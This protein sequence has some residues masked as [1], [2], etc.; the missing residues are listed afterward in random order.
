MERASIDGT[1]SHT[2]SAKADGDG[3][4][5]LEPAQTSDSSGLL[6]ELE[7]RTGALDAAPTHFMIIDMRRPGWPIVFVNRAIARDNGY[8][9]E[10]LLGQGPGMLVTSP[11]NAAAL[12]EV[13]SAMRRGEPARAQLRSY[14]KDGTSFWAGVSFW[15]MR[16][17]AG[18]TTHYVSIGAD[19]TAR[20]EET[21]NRER[22]QRQLYDEMQQR[23]Q[24]AIE[25]RFA[26]KLESVG[27]L[28]AG[29]AHEINTPIQYIG[30]SVRF[31]QETFSSLDVLVDLCRRLIASLSAGSISAAEA[32]QRV[33]EAERQIDLEFLKTEAP[34]A[35]ERTLDGV[36]RVAS[37]V[38]AMKEFAHPDANEQALAD[39]NHAIETTLTVAHSEYKYFATVDMRFDHLPEV[40]CNI[41]EL[42]QVFLNLIVNAAHAIEQSGKDAHMGRIEISTKLQGAYVAIDFGDNG[43]GIP[44][45][46]LEKIFD[47]FFTTKEVGRGTGQGLA[48][49]RSIVVDKHCGSIDVQSTAG[50]GTHFILRL[51][52]SGPGQVKPA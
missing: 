38:R 51:P 27:R 30:D 33:S 19:I 50:V 14:R 39:I 8:E 26:Q 23:E 47:P 41:G 29:I 49:A 21:E 7:L 35:F 1:D 36:A 52:L 44:P 16:N 4:L 2:A 34:K 11:E 20:L 24:M 28:A 22:L 18:I 13:Q 5:R 15:P 42:N 9:P 10:E 43:C 46:N 32:C 25:L 31:L 37:I 3:E 12:H 6:S 48:I 45:E 17:A 40:L